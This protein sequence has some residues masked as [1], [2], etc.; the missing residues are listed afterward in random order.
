MNK[1]DLLNSFIA[2]EMSVYN[3]LINTNKSIR[4]GRNCGKDLKELKLQRKVVDKLLSKIKLTKN[5]L[6]VCDKD[7]EECKVSY[8]LLK[9]SY[10]KI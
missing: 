7:F 10:L 9:N 5:G 6:E 1:D 2:L 4:D 8:T 3:K